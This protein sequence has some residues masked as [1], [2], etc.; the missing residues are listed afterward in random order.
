MNKIGFTGTRKGMTNKQ[1]E[2]FV[3]V[4][5]NYSKPLIEFHHGDCIGADEQAHDIARVHGFYIVIHP[6]I[7]PNRRAFCEGG[8]ILTPRDYIPRNHDIVDSSDII[9]ATP[10][11]E[12]EVIRSGTWATI[13]YAI[14][15][16]KTLRIIYPSGLSHREGE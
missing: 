13:R 1:R 8:V 4:I 2:M 15:K 16:G 14:K 3:Q 11:E 5:A 7:N 6:P 9:I 12:H 10:G